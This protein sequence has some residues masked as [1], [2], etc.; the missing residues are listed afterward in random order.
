MGLKTVLPEIIHRIMPTM[1]LSNKTLISLAEMICGGAGGSGFHWDNF[2]YRSS[3]YLTEFFLACDLPFR[4]D[5]STRKSWVLGCLEKLN[6]YPSRQPQ[7]PSPPLMR[8]IA[9]LLDPI[10]LRRNDKDPLAALADVN[11]TM[12]RDGLEAYY[13]DAERCHIRSIGTSVSSATAAA[14]TTWSPQEARRRADI[15]HRLDQMSEDEL[16]VDF[17]RPLFAQ[18]GFKRLSV[19]GHKD[20]SLEYGTDL[21][22]K[23]RLPTAQFLYFAVQVKKGK[24][25]AA[26]KTKNTNVTEVLNQVRMALDHAVFDPEMNKLVL[27]DH[28]FI[29]SAGEITKQAKAWLAQRLDSDS[30]RQV[31]FMD[32]DDLLTLAVETRFSFT[33]GHDGDQE[34]ANVKPVP[35]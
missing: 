21:W 19:A 31:M 20:K 17:L 1:R 23:F 32:R 12:R 6:E 14:E 28:V 16:I 9:E 11:Q 22:M 35:F 33:N 3:S 18:V 26:G 25:D 15:G 8:V 24:L 34:E 10:E 7:L 30:R 5:G 13:D 29:I 27:V 4:H 2:P